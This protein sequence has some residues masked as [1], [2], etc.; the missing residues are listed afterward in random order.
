MG[1]LI[2]AVVAAVCLLPSVS[3]AQLY[4]ADR[5]GSCIYSY[6]DTVGTVVSPLDLTILQVGRMALDH[7]GRVLIAGYFSPPSYV[8]RLDPVTETY[9]LLFPHSI[10]PDY[11][12]VGIAPSE[13]DDILVLMQWA[14]KA[15]AGRDNPTPDDFISILP[16]GSDPPKVA[17]TFPSVLSVI[18][19]KVRPL[20]TNAG[21]L[22]VLI[23]DLTSY[24]C[25]FVELAPSG[26]DT[27]AYY[28]SI[29]AEA[30]M[31][32]D[33]RAFAFHPSGTIF[34][35]DYTDGLFFVDETY[36]EV[37]AFG[38]ASGPG[39]GD[40]T[41]DPNGDIYLANLLTDRIEHF[42]SSGA[43]MGPPFGEDLIALRAV[44]AAGFTPTP[45]GEN[46]LVK[47]G[48]NIEITYGEVVESGFTTAVVETSASRTSPLGNYLPV[49]A[50]LPGSRADVFTYVSLSTDAVYTGFIQTD[51]ILEGSRLFFA[52][53]VGDT[54]RDLTVVGS[55][56][57]ARG[58]IPRFGELPDPGAKLRDAWPTEVVL[59]ED[60]RALPEVV[61]YKFWCLELAMA[62]PDTVPFCPWGAIYGL[63]EYRIGARSAYDQGDYEGALAELALMNAAIRGYAGTCIP[64]RS[65]A[66]LGNRVGRILARSKTLMFSI[67]L[68]WDETSVGDAEIPSTISLSLVNPTHGECRMFLAGPAGTDVTV[69]VFD[70]SGRL[71]TTV[72]DG[73]MPEGGA[74]VL[75]DGADSAG[76]RVASGV[77]FA[78][79]EADGQSVTSKVAYI[80]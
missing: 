58:T 21:N 36:G 53:G 49:Y 3:T 51:V 55:V 60:A 61:H 9:D 67:Q 56:E 79:A 35:V 57:D 12:P 18:D 59:V 30:E 72:Y 24:G 34:I 63:R 45:E 11:S 48:E 14:T 7:D 41:V 43:S 28:Q 25:Y 26:E 66:I 80:R 71:V 47:P 50:A 29:A 38:T 65:D 1:L 42:S 75:W 31:P 6:S 44:V 46:V 22:V 73:P 62:T 74:D 16:G 64:D 54:F 19:M 77:Y 27:F 70:V 8:A 37:W 4:A 69:R 2:V 10:I 39:L 23:N 20:G 32:S 40:I 76:N 33:P 5:D 52:T 68:E 13:G 78:K 15:E 17:Y